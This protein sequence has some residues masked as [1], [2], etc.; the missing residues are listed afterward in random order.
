MS[1]QDIFDITTFLGKL[2]V[3]TLALLNLVLLWIA[4]LK[5]WIVPGSAF[6]RTVAEKDANLKLADDATTQFE[7]SLDLI[8]RMQD[9]GRRNDGRR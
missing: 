4:F 2:S 6:R 7:R 8:E 9:R 1:P 5:E 3:L